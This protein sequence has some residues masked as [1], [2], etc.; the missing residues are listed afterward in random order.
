[1]Q[2]HARWAS[3]CSIMEE[4]PLRQINSNRLKNLQAHTARF[5]LKNSFAIPKL[6]D[7][8]RIFT[9]WKFEKF[10]FIIRLTL[11][12]AFLEYCQI[13]NMTNVEPNRHFLSHLWFGY[14]ACKWHITSSLLSFYANFQDVF[15]ATEKAMNH[16]SMLQ[17][18]FKKMSHEAAQIV[19]FITSQ[20][21]G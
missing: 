9:V 8:V 18:W 15:L 10:Y 2:F 7:L 20:A 14:S 4:R 3:H 19:L 13:E 17:I 12:T 5:L 21:K 11:R 6:T 1:M 16:V